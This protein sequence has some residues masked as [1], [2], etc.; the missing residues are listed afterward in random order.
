MTAFD[1]NG[2]EIP[3]LQEDKLSVFHGTDKK[4]AGTLILT[5]ELYQY[6]KEKWSWTWTWIGGPSGPL[7][8]N[9]DFNLDTS[10]TKSFLNLTLYDTIDRPRGVRAV[11]SS[12]WSNTTDYPQR[13]WFVMGDGI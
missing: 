11:I 9:F 12:R 13:P 4:H 10:R 7:A 1:K 2:N 3:T 5:E 6:Q 8:G